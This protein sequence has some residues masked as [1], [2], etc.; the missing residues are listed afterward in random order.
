MQCYNGHHSFTLLDLKTANGYRFYCMGIYHFQKRRHVI[1][2]LHIIFNV[3][4]RF[5]FINKISDHQ[6]KEHVLY[7]SVKVF[8]SIGYISSADLYLYKNRIMA[9]YVYIFKMA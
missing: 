7:F 2:E 9:P 6:I 5:H 8:K 3:N 1:N 4:V